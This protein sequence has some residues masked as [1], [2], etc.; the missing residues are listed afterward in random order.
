MPGGPEVVGI[1]LNPDKMILRQDKMEFHGHLITK[2]GLRPDPAKV[3]V[4]EGMPNPTC[5]D[6][7]L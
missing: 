4:I 5:T 7:I 2:E 3:K 1:C 6:D